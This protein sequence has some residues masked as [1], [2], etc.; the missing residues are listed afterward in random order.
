MGRKS[1]LENSRKTRVKNPYSR[2]LRKIVRF[3]IIF[4]LVFL[5]SCIKGNKTKIPDN[6]LL[7]T[8]Q[9]INKLCDKIYKCYYGY[10]RTIPKNLQNKLSIQNCREKLL[11][12]LEEK[13]SLHDN[14]T[15]QLAVNC[16]QKMLESSCQRFMV[17]SFAESSCL[18]LR[19]KNASLLKNFG[20]E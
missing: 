15:K 10:Y 8:K 20:K 16:Y 11:D 12:R 9:K 6:Y 5:F 14:K 3:L 1:I 13:I 18:S 7:F 2:L 19:N 17:V 4:I